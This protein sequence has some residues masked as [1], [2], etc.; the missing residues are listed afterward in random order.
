MSKSIA[1]A[2]P[3]L[4]VEDVD[5]IRLRYMRVLERAGYVAEG[6]GSL[7][8]ANEKIRHK[9]F[10]VAV[11][12]LNLQDSKNDAG[13]RSGYDVI[14][15]V[16]DTGEGTEPLVVTGQKDFGSAVESIKAGTSNLLAKN[17]ITDGSVLVSRVNELSSKFKLRPIGNYQ[18]LHAYL[19]RPEN[20]AEWESIRMSELGLDATRFDQLVSYAFQDILP[21][22][23]LENASFSL[24]RE[25]GAGKLEGIFWSRK[26]GLAVS[27]SLSRSTDPT[28][29]DSGDQDLILQREKF[30]IQVL[31]RRVHG[32]SVEEFE[33]KI[34]VR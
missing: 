27:V 30:G 22:R 4:V 12:D 9:T 20:R 16:I 33:G 34:V 31:V 19:C 2:F 28:L 5:D 26:L 14:R 10:S 17:E 23:R 1:L 8:E 18:H 29:R 6:A 15:A 11:I 13:D 21:V 7:L 32:R 3:V 25:T 24:G